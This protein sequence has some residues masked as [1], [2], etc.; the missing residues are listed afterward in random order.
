VIVEGWRV[1]DSSIEKA[2]HAQG[3]EGIDE[4]EEDD[5]EDVVFEGVEGEGD[6][7]GSTG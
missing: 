6:S 4:V 5:F 3:V 7:T 2:A 1:H